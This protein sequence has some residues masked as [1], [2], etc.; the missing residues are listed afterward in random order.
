MKFY[1]N[2][3]GMNDYSAAI[4]LKRIIPEL[5]NVNTGIIHDHLLG[6]DLEFY[7]SKKK[8][9]PVWIR[10][11]MPFALIAIILMLI[12]MP[13]KFL[14]TGEWGYHNEKISNWFR[15]IGF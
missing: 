8:S 15:A 9:V 1:W 11:T 4:E 12:L 6:S 14:F 5:K 7:E 13:V 2:L 10:F 3:R